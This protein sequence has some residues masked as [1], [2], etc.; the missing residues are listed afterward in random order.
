MTRL[1]FSRELRRGMW[2][3]G[4]L[5]VTVKMTTYT[6]IWRVIVVSVMTSCAIV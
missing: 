4:G 2:W 3:I 5:V 1:A 6:G